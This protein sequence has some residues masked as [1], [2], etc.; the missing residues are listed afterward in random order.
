M[1]AHEVPPEYQDNHNGY[2]RLLV[3]ESSRRDGRASGRVEQRLLRTRGV[4]AG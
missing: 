3:D 4:H 2:M 1:S